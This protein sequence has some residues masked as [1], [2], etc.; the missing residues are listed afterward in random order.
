MQGTVEC[1]HPKVLGTGYPRG[2]MQKGMRGLGG[3]EV[4]SSEVSPGH[5]AI[6]QGKHEGGHQARTRLK[7]EGGRAGG[8]AGVVV[9]GTQGSRDMRRRAHEIPYTGQGMGRYSKLI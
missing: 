8:A 4:Q 9:D 6:S 1:R 7:V 3:G 2:G 5:D